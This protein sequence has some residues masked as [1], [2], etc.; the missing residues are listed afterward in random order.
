MF[1]SALL[2]VSVVIFHFT[3]PDSLSFFSFVVHYR[4]N[5]TDLDVYVPPIPAELSQKVNGGVT[6]VS[7]VPTGL[8]VCGASIPSD[9]SLG[10]YHKSLRDKAFA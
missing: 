6:S 9:E 2:C 8:W 1:P 10:Y 3:M 4:N 5:G 7:V